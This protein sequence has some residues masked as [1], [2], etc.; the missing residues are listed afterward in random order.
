MYKRQALTINASAVTHA[1]DADYIFNYTV[2][3]GWTLLSG[4]QETTSRPL[5]YSGRDLI[6]RVRNTNPVY[7]TNARIEIFKEMVAASTSFSD[8]Q[9][10]IVNL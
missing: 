1:A 10:K 7:A 9:S 8:F 6:I 3:G 5:T 2:S 4:A